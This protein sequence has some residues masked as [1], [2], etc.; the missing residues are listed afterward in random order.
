[1]PYIHLGRRPRPTT[2]HHR[3]SPITTGPGHVFFL[4]VSLNCLLAQGTPHRFKFTC[5]VC[6][7]YLASR[8]Q[9]PL[10]TTDASQICVD[11]TQIG[12]DFTQICVESKQ[13]CVES[14]QICVESIQ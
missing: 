6:I 7:F 3:F 13:I 9:K 8:I 11:S 2:P 14:K 10:L 5:L 1:M 12:V 4:R